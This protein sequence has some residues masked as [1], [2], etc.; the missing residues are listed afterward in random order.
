MSLANILKHPELCHL[1]TPTN[2][3]KITSDTITLLNF[4]CSSGFKK[5]DSQSTHSKSRNIYLLS[6]LDF[7][8]YTLDQ[9]IDF[10]SND[11][12]SFLPGLFVCK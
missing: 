10:A 6:F 3:K 8:N 11:F 12:F 9:I 4:E 5:F 7:L 2:C 1:Q